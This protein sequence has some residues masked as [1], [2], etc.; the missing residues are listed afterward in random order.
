[1]SA[2]NGYPLVEVDGELVQDYKS[3]IGGFTPENLPIAGVSVAPYYGSV[4]NTLRYKEIE[5]SANISWKAGHVFRR[6]SMAPA[7]EYYSADR[8]HFDYLKRWKTPGD[9]K[10]T[11]VPA[12]ADAGLGDG[13]VAYRYSRVLVTKGNQ[14]R[15]QDVNINYTLSKNVIRKLPVQ[16]IHFMLMP[17]I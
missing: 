8:Y 12:W 5:L 16:N 7:D 10:F 17:E 14:I 1:M 3:F 6:K 9:E 13:D 2:E 11:E 15:L 4:R